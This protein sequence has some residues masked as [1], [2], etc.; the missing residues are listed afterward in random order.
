M[1]VFIDLFQFDFSLQAFLL[2]LF[3]KSMKKVCLYKDDFKIENN[4]KQK[5][6]VTR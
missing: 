2:L 6:E 5:I 4:D 3:C 1:F